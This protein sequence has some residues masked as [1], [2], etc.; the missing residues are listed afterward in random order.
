M[1]N[2]ALTLI[3]YNKLSW[4]EALTWFNDLI[5]ECEALSKRFNIGDEFEF[6]WDITK[7]PFEDA[8]KS[9]RIFDK[10]KVAISL[11]KKN[12]WILSNE[13][14]QSL[15]QLNKRL[16]AIYPELEKTLEKY[17]KHTKLPHN[18]YCITDRL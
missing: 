12:N 9:V 17:D 6:G 14:K 5:D 10:L 8:V 13:Q 1:T 7:D 15:Q 16:E 11:S 3:S 4:L 2:S 18:E